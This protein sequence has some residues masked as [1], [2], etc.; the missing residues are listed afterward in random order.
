MNEMAN[1]NEHHHYI[2]P[3]GTCTARYEGEGE[4][5]FRTQTAKKSQIMIL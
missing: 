4:P 1:S 3:D 2:L 5:F